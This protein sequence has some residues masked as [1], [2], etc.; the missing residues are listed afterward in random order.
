MN[1]RKGRLGYRD[2]VNVSLGLAV[3]SVISMCLMRKGLGS[4]NLSVDGFAESFIDE[5]QS[6]ACVCNGGIATAIDFGAI[7]EGTRRVDFPEAT[8]FVDYGS[9]KRSLAA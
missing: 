4:R 6:C 9:I 2:G 1:S 3:I 7:D 8:F 5:A